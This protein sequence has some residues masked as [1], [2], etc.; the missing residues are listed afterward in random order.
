MGQ[1]PGGLSCY[2]R[3]PPHA[4]RLSGEDIK[5]LPPEHQRAAKAI[6]DKG[7]QPLFP[8]LKALYGHPCS[9][10]LWI[11]HRGDRFLRDKGWIEV[12][13]VTGRTT[14]APPSA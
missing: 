1:R 10:H 3:V 11:Q 12:P 14:T 2:R 8:M 13:G 5:A 6:F 9:G 4:I 7:E